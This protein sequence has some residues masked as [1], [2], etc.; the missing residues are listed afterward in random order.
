[1]WLL[2][3]WHERLSTMMGIGCAFSEVVYTGKMALDAREM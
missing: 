2:V 1:M 3:D